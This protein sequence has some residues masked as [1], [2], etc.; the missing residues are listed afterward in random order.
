MTKYSWMLP[1]QF[2][3][4]NACQPPLFRCPIKG[5]AKRSG[6]G[7]L[8]RQEDKWL[9]QG[10]GVHQ[11]NPTIILWFPRSYNELT[12]LAYQISPA[13]FCSSHPCRDRAPWRKITGHLNWNILQWVERLSAK[14]C[15]LQLKITQWLSTGFVQLKNRGP[16]AKIRIFGKINKS[17][18]ETRSLLLLSEVC[19]AN[20][21]THIFCISSNFIIQAV[22]K[23]KIG[24]NSE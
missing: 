15:I 3:L 23:S 14:R 11:R 18:A 6:Y 24:Y 8:S 4:E 20:I 2:C 5:T 19:L 1:C 12:H 9:T 17:L 21:N 7:K 16:R 22:S 13:W 10:W